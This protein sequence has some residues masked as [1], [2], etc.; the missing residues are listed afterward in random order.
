MGDI[1]VYIET[2]AGKVLPIALELLSAARALA[3]TTGGLVEAALFGAAPHAIAAE[4]GSAD[5]VLV[6]AHP[7]LESYTPEA[8][9]AALLEVV[10][11]RNPQVVLLGYTTIGLDLAPALA[12]HTNLPLVGYCRKCAIAGD[13]LEAESLIYGGKLAA[14]TRSPLPAV[15]AITPGSYPEAEA[16]PAAAA[17]IETLEPP[18]LGAPRMTFVRG[19]APDPNA[20]DITKAGKI[21]CVGRG[22][23]DR[24]SV[25]LAEQVAVLLGAEVAGSRPII[26]NGWL[27]KER[28]VGKSGRKVAPKLYFAVGVSGAPEHLEGMRGAELIVAINTDA[29]APIFEVAHFGATCD[30]FELLPALEERLK[31]GAA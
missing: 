1:L 4:L 28:Q 11:R 18:A 17:S 8:H 13:T 9:G 26:D 6:I 15:V 19:T 25:A 20:V 14:A 29:R 31:S 10:R 7:A 21:L 16:R 5:R 12:L 27:P 30:L 22:I 23:G 24:D 3:A 2:R